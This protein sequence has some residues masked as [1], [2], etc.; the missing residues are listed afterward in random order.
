[1][2]SE[3]VPKGDFEHILVAL[4]PENRLACEISLA[5]GLRINDVLSLK[6][7]QVAKQR[8]TVYEQK[9]G[10]SRSVRL[11]VELVNR[12]LACSGQ[13]YVFA[14]R[15]NGRKHRTRQAVFKD[16]KRVADV[17]RM[18]QNVCPH[19]LRKSFA[20]EEFQKN[21]G[22]LKRVQKLL[23]HSSEAVTMLYAMANISGKRKQFK[24]S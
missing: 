21:G 15:L 18:K 3:W 20:V 24:K 10:K 23:N 19:S 7:L 5:T 9:T 22:D 14:H 16:L 1:M 17:F 13:H 8:F 2:R 4:T 6:P 11:P 12:A